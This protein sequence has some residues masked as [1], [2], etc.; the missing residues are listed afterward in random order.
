MLLLLYFVDDIDVKDAES[1]TI[2]QKIQYVA[3]E[4]NA[5]DVVAVVLL[6]SLQHLQNFNLILIISFLYQTNI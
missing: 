5:Y 2:V 6:L 1:E 3:E 4:V